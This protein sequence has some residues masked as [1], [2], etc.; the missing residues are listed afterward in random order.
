MLFIKKPLTINVYSLAIWRKIA[1]QTITI[2]HY[3]LY[4][5]ERKKQKTHYTKVEAEIIYI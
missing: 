2:E 3:V 4:E 1:A 5:K